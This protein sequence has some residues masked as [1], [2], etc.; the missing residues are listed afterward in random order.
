MTPDELIQLMRTVSIAKVRAE[1]ERWQKK[2]PEGYAY[3]MDFYQR[4]A[5]RKSS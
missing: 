3:F 4:A 1:L 5:K 2:A